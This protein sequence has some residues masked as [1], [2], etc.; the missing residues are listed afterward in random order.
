MECYLCYYASI[1]S[2]EDDDSTTF[3]SPFLPVAP[4][5]VPISDLP[6]IL[7][8]FLLAK[9]LFNT[10][11]SIHSAGNPLNADPLRTLLPK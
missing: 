9:F 5:Y 6:G 3:D 8:I 10:S 11:S 1:R 7:T 4:S 2:A